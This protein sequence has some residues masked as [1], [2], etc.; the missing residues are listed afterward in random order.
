MIKLILILICLSPLCVLAQKDRQVFTNDSFSTSV[1]KDS[2]RGK[3]ILTIRDDN[4]NDTIARIEDQGFSTKSL[5]RND[6]LCSILL[7]GNSCDWIASFW[8]YK[9]GAQ[10]W[11]P[12]DSEG[13]SNCPTNWK[14][15]ESFEIS[16]IGLLELEVITTT[17]WVSGAVDVVKEQ[18]HYDG[19]K[20]HNWLKN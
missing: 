16:Q 20:R 15:S 8:I 1:W 11:E 12:I 6:T 10:Y 2:L 4:L 14:R 3:Y 18:Y 19:N 7:T 13:W 5:F 9:K 17:R